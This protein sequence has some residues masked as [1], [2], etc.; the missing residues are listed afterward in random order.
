MIDRAERWLSDQVQITNA[1]TDTDVNATTG[2]I[3][4]DICEQRIVACLIQ[5]QTADRQQTEGRTL[6]LADR[7]VALPADTEVIA[8]D[9]IEVT[10]CSDL[11]LIGRFGTITD[12]ERDS[13]RAR[14]RITVRFDSG[15]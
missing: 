10:G 14:R 3:T 15:D 13:L 5:E 12:V 8:G 9:R 11:S 4:T 1:T 7:L 2:A 6:G